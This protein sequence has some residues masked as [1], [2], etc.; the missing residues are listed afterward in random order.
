M[1]LLMMTC[2]KFN[3]TRVVVVVVLMG[4]HHREDHSVKSRDAFVK[5]RR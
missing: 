5:L 3:P 4:R 2:D 1:L